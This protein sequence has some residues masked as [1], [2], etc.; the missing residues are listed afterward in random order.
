[1]GIFQV[2]DLVADIISCLDQID[3]GMTG[4]LEWLAYLGLADN[5]QILGN[6]EVEALLGIEETKLALLACC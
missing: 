5:A 6:A 3:E 4:K 2:H 1:M